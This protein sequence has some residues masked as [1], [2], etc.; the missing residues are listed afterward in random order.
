MVSCLYRSTLL[1]TYLLLLAAC[2]SSGG[3]KRVTID[4][5]V[6]FDKVVFSASGLDYLNTEVSP[7]RG[8]TVQ[9]R[10][11][12]GME[13]SSTTTDE[14]G[15]YR[16]QQVLPNTRF[17][18][19]VLAELY[20]DS[21]AA[22]HASVKD[23]TDNNALYALQ[24]SEFSSGLGGVVLD[25]HAASGWDVSASAYS[26]ARSAA[27]F[28]ILDAIYDGIYTLL[29]VDD[30]IRFSGLDI[31]WSEG[32]NPAY[33]RDLSFAEN[34]SNGDIGS[35]FYLNDA[36]YILG[37]DSVNTDEYDRHVI[38]HE[39]THFLE[40]TLSR[41][42][43]TGGSHNITQSL[44][45]RLAY[46]EGLANAFSGVTTGDPIYRDSFG[47]EQSHDFKINLESNPDAAGGDNAGWYIEGSIHS[48][49]YD[50]YDSNNEGD[51][52]ITLGLKPIY[53]VLTSDDYVSQ[54]SAVTIFS[55]VDLLKRHPAVNSSAL[56][57]LF[58][59][60]EI[61]GVD[62]YGGGEI[63]DGGIVDVLPVYKTIDVGGA[64]TLIC[65]TNLLGEFNRLGNRQL[66][67]LSAM[68][69]QHTISVSKSSGVQ[70]ANPA[71][72]VYR[73]GEVVASHPV[74]NTPAYLAD[75]DVESATVQLPEDGD[76]L[77]E[78]LS[79]RNID[80]TFSTGGDICFDVS[81]TI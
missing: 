78:V 63:N 75:T 12:D 53:D 1:L 77:L 62:A 42:D 25:I 23:N 50:L 48:L 27:P 8:I 49:I 60:Q 24:S 35:T 76:Y 15:F 29:D 52:D 33:D 16:F 20:S 7:A 71:F 6:T 72:V 34:V 67:K 66:L 5:A 73:Q 38:L 37:A 57:S 31:F 28:A 64:S 11:A 55:F 58:A 41:S 65:S 2:G 81:V 21:Q 46:T 69:G 13:V 51:D 47:V 54:V 9:L 45:P 32:N 14:N 3:G 39:W 10:D 18:V 56:S 19:F 61:F 17:Q 44:D 43:T 30:A 80:S 40:D 79:R 36:M 59:T 74:P 4:G 26:T 68:A 22:W 70:S